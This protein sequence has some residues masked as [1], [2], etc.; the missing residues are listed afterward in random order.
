M[1][2]RTFTYRA[3][4]EDR[5]A[6]LGRA[7]AEVLPPGS[8]VALHGTLG[9]GKTRLVQALAAGLGIAPGEVTSP[10]FV[11]AQEY[12]GRC[13]L[14]HLDAYRLKDAAE[15]EGLGI[16]DYFSPTAIT[17]IEWAERIESALPVERLDVFIE[18]EPDG[19]RRF[20]LSARG[21]ALQTALARLNPSPTGL[22]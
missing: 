7:L 15:A 21:T 22:P 2:A 20:E 12:E 10:T 9:A 19:A 3:E 4:N 17:C 11:L 6:V 1:T 13:M 8:L 18:I 16:E 5:T 14:Y